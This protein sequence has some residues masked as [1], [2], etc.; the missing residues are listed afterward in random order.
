M[1]A[2]ACKILL[3]ETYRESGGSPA[4]RLSA[5]IRSL[6]LL[7][8]LGHEALL[9]ESFQLHPQVLI[10]VIPLLAQ[11]QFRLVLL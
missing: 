2:A 11:E 5:L 3:R 7:Q 1:T 4:R 6:G 10:R 9:V 8:L